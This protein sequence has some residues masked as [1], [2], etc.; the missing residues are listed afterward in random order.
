MHTVVK[1]LQDEA[2]DANSVLNRRGAPR[3]QELLLLVENLRSALIE[4]DAIVQRYQGLARRER[5]IW[6][7]LKFASED[8]GQVRGKLTFHLTAINVF[9]ESLSRSTLSQIEKTLLELIGEVR[10]GRRPPSIVP[11]DERD[12]RSVW[13][14][15]EF[16]LAEDGISKADVAQHKAAIKIFL[17]GRIQDIA[18][19]TMSLDEV[20]SRVESSNEHDDSEPFPSP[21]TLDYRA[22]T[23]SSTA[24][25]EQYESAVEELADE[26]NA[27]KMLPAPRVTCVTFADPFKLPPRPKDLS[28]KAS[29]IDERLQHMPMRRTS[30]GSIYRYRH[31]ID[32]SVIE[33]KP[34]EPKQEL[35]GKAEMRP[36][37][38][39]IL[40]IDPTHSSISRLAHAYLR[41]LV[42]S[43]A[44]VRDHIDT[45]RSTGWQE[46]ESSG[47]DS[48]SVGRLMRELLGRRQIEVP[49]WGSGFRVAAFRLRDVIEFDHVI[50]FNS[51]TFRRVLKE[52]IKTIAALKESYG[53]TNKSLARLTGFDLPSL[54]TPESMSEEV[55]S[56]AILL[57]RQ[58]LALEEVFRWIQRWLLNFLEQEYG[59][60]RS[61]EGFERLSTRRPSRA[62]PIPLGNKE[63][64]SRSTE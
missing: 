2:G 44:I 35:T 33:L 48:L 56:K 55:S 26:A 16:E 50:H 46:H 63:T 23:M 6:D 18:A 37:K 22:P 27:I 64:R 12:E 28:E 41:S 13:S 19:E 9:T 32:A 20:A 3:R 29:E 58:R 8:L 45:V 24:G 49:D 43:H 36:K 39:M 38:E 57:N 30:A 42:K 34:I 1:D 61:G 4:I 15:L 62:S 14:E 54:K 47:I 5:R 21:M 59:L 60:K 51:P 31:S 17:Q 53:S 40:I 25:S 52:N 7:Q 11:S 10:E